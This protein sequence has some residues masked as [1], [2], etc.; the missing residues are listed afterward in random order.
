MRISCCF[1]PMFYKIVLTLIILLANQPEK[2]ISNLS[3]ETME[4]KD[5]IYVFDAHC[6]WCY[7]F[8]DVILHFSEKHKNEYNFK[9]LSGG[10]ITGERVGPIGAMSDYILKAIPNLEKTTG[11]KVGQ[12]YIDVLKDGTRVQNSLIPAKALCVLKEML[13][14]QEIMLAHKVQELQ[15]VEG[16]NLQDQVTYIDLCN[17]LGLSADDFLKKFE[18]SDYEQKAQQEFAQSSA[19]GI[20]GFPAVV[21]DRGDTL[22]AM[23]NGYTNLSSLEENLLKAEKYSFDNSK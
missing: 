1:V 16:K 18:S 12:A 15:F 4:K 14:N 10:L 20:R 11:M 9:V 21:L 17:D 3:T 2:Q 8:S 23:S 7:G 13:P 5:I 6:G 19:W 22:L